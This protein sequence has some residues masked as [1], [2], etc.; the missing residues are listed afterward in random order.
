MEQSAYRSVRG[1][2]P[3]VLVSPLQAVSVPQKPETPL[4]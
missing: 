4:R 3:E 1:V 2:R